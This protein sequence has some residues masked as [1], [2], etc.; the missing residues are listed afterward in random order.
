MD[1]IQSISHGNEIFAERCCRLSY[2]VICHEKYNPALQRHFGRPIVKD[3][4][5]GQTLV[6]NQIVWFVKQV[7]SLFMLNCSVA[8]EYNQ[9]EK[10]SPV[11]VF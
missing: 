1:R 9:R 6:E 4:L 10:L 5:N 11:M 2:G 3:P 7:S 8:E